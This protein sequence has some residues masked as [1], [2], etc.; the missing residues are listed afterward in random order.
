MTTGAR[1]F[2]AVRRPPG[3][4]GEEAVWAINGV[5][6]GPYPGCRAAHARGVVCGGEFTPAPI[7]AGLTRAALMRGAPVPVTVRFS[8]ASGDPGKP[9]SK[10]DNRGMA[11][12]FHGADRDMDIV[13]VSLPCFFSRTPEDFVALNRATRRGRRLPARPHL[14]IDF[15]ARHRE[16]RRATWAA[17]R[18]KPVPSYANCRY[19]ALHTFVW[20]DPSGTR[21]YVRY[22][23]R[24]EAGEATLAPRAARR[25]PPDFLQRDLTERLGR[26]PSRPMRFTLE[27]QVAPEGARM[28]DSEDD[29]I[30]DPTKVW[31]RDRTARDPTAVVAAGVLEVTEL[32]DVTEQLV[33]DPVPRVDGIGPSNDRI[34]MFRPRA[35]EASAAVRGRGSGQA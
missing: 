6:G 3:M 13:A 24:P 28:T 27:V 20:T 32:L 21:R 1:A 34:L 30:N 16:A 7:A 15:L 25:L 23:W 31:R 35:Y 11:T 29:A 2:P 22:S 12:R 5:F 18:A 17:L 4:S 9:D 14:L 19:N 26:T 8:N 10:G 33:F